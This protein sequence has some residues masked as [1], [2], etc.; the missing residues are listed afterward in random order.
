MSPEDVVERAARVHE[1][2]AAT[3]ARA[4]DVHEAA[5]EL[6]EQHADEMFAAGRFDEGQRAVLQAAYERT[7]ASESRFRADIERAMAATED[8]RSHA[9]RN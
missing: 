5:A 4:A 8:H 1:R 3:H 6:Q 2:A 7:A 9:T